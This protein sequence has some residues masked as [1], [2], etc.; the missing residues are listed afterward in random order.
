MAD[1][2]SIRYGLGA[3]KGVGEAAVAAIVEARRAG[4]AFTDVHD[5]CSRIDLTRVNKRCLEA[6][7]KAGAFDALGANRATLM[8][9][10]PAAVQG[11]EQ[12]TRA[13]THGQGSLFEM[14]AA[15]VAPP[16]GPAARAA[17]EADWPAAVR[18]AYERETLGHYL[19]GHPI[20]E[21][22]AR[23]QV[24]RAGAHR[25]AHRRAAV[26]RRG[27]VAAPP[28]NL[29][30]A[31]LVLD[32]RTRGNRTSIVLDDGSGRLE[33]SLFDEVL[34]QHREIIAKDAILVVEGGLRCDRVP[35]GL[36]AVGRS[37]SCR[38]DA[39]R[40]AQARRLLLRWPAG[41]D[42]AALLAALEA[43]L[44]P[45]RGG[46]CAVAIYY[47][48][49]RRERAPRA[50]RR[51]ER[52]P[53]ARALLESLARAASAP[54]ARGSSTTRATS[55]EFLTAWGALGTGRDAAPQDDRL[56]PPLDAAGRAWNRAAPMDLNFL[57]FEQP[58]AELEA[59]IDELRYLGD[60]AEI[61][62]VEEINKLP[63]QEPGADEE[64]LREPDARGSSRS[65]RATRSVPTR[66]T[67]CRSCSPTSRS[68]TAT[69]CTP[70]TS[71][72]SAGR[73]GSTAAR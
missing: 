61:N 17:A 29:T 4:G 16:S 9:A 73:R 52:A 68:C 54:T 8:A 5:L 72:S 70:T 71:R 28:R 41:C 20:D 32:I 46:R 42:E 45:V 10:L 3:V 23:P 13:A 48:G 11:G 18:L 55:S 37:A 38:I 64:H 35:R 6:L 59:K 50:R 57:D 19:S 21:Y 53:D 25:R 44:K 15:P 2:S 62:I 12:R 34:Q 65:S 69:G 26:R 33:V 22:A 51:L 58:I 30:V 66:S 27:Q 43:A 24:P 36:A 67:T 1:A 47:P 14:G 39:A 60:D 49:A 40:E 56:R 7:L 31:G 63:R